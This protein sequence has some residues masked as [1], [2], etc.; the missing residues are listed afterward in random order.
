MVP[1]DRAAAARKRAEQRETHRCGRNSQNLPHH[2]L[3]SLGSLIAGTNA[4]D[5]DRDVVGTL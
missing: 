3:H 1:A 4:M 2:A 5:N